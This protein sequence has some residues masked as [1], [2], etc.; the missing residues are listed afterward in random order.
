MLE[1]LNI[2]QEFGFNNENLFSELSEDFHTKLKSNLISKHYDI[3]AFIFKEGERPLGVYRVISGKVKKITRT[4]FGTEHIFYICKELEYLGYHAVLG[5][6]AYADS[7]VAMVDCVIEFIPIADFQEVVEA[8]KKLSQR[9]LKTLS[10]EFRVYINATKILAKYTVRERTALNLLILECKFRS[11]AIGPTEIVINRDDL[12]SMVGTAKETVV[13]TLK[14][15]K[16]D[17]L[18]ATKRSSIFIL[19]YERLIDASCF[20]K[21]SN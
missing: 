17:N 16:D 10:H 9:L 15:F 6:E 13:R 2:S 20:H 8:S 18:I 12:A 4:D 19:N 21:N 11:N 7:A 14:E 1:T 5:Q 3:G